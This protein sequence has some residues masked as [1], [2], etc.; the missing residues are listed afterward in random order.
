MIA[1]LKRTTLF[2]AL[3]ALIIPVSEAADKIKMK[4][5]PPA[6]GTITQMSLDEVTIEQGSVPKKVPV[7]EIISI[8]YDKEPAA[9]TSLVR[10]AYEDGR[11]SDALVAVNK[12]DAAD[13]ERPEILQDLAFYKAACS[14]RLALGGSGSPQ[15]AGRLLIAF[16]SKHSGN[17]H[18]LEVCQLLGDLLVAA[19]KPDAAQKYYDKLAN[20]TFPEYK[21][22]A[23]VLVARALESQKQYQ[24]A[25][26][27]YDEVISGEGN[28]KDAIG[29]KLAATCGKASAMA[30]TGKAD[31]AVKMVEEVISKADAADLELH[32]RAYNA[33]GSCYRSAGKKKEALIA[34]LHTDLLFAGFPEQHAE[35]LA[36]LSTLWAE[37]D[38]VDRATQAKATLKERYPGS[39][40]AQEKK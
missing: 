35:A 12:I 28:S 40:W 29:H 32:A 30:A 20:S 34:Y 1:M 4:Q 11:F 21:L 3:V 25:I 2:L 10:N 39:R 8:E 7:N 6:A 36:A 13:I 24:K 38:K 31:E 14:A 33:L 5:G 15:D 27:E 9:M 23:G 37:V 26:A 17:Y 18:Y 16:E 19:G 22:L